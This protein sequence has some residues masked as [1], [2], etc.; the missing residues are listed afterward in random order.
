[1][2]KL[3]SVDGLLWHWNHQDPTAQLVA[4]HVL[5][6]VEASGVLVFPSTATGWYFDDKVAQKY[7]LEAVG[8]PIAQAHVFY[9]FEEACR[10]IDDAS[11]PK[12]FKLRKG[13]GSENVRLVRTRH[14]AYI[15][16]KRAFGNGF[17]PVPAYWNDAARRYQ[18]AQQRGD[19]LGAL[20]RLP[21]TLRNIRHLN[22]TIGRE[23]GY[24]YFQDFI[25]DNQFDTRVTVIGDRAFAY[26][27][28]VR[29]GDFR[30]S[31]SG[32]IDYSPQRIRLE[33]V[34]TA[35]NV[36]RKIGSQ[37]MA[38]DFVLT[39]EG[40]PMI[41]E[42]SYC[43]VP[44][45]VHNCEGHWD[46]RLNWHPGQVWPEDAILIDLV[47]TI[48]PRS[49]HAVSNIQLSNSFLSSPKTSRN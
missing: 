10:W 48:S 5:M 41:V 27:R 30:A 42:V 2:Q 17:R 13:A 36:T 14:E 44:E 46:Q 39:R 49:R 40:Q 25:P 26:V 24:I 45:Y 18:I 8:A 3:T 34:E 28:K 47:N 6:A 19:L 22:Q 15:L 1:M 4:R 16:A 38:F 29:P 43:Y 37:S 7:L 21:T 35:F 11:F 32:N 20:K 23:K 31:G 9:T 33:C 12:V